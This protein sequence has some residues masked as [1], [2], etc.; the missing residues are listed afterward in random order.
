M[1]HALI[2]NGI[3]AQTDPVAGHRAGGAVA[4][5]PLL[6]GARPGC[7]RTADAR[8]LRDSACARG[9]RWGVIWHDFCERPMKK[10]E[11]RHPRHAPRK[12]ARLCPISSLDVYH[13]NAPRR[14]AFA[15]W[16]SVF[17]WERGEMMRFVLI[18][19]VGKTSK[20]RRETSRHTAPAEPAMGSRR[21]PSTVPAADARRL[22]DVGCAFVYRSGVIRRDFCESVMSKIENRN[23]WCASS[24]CRVPGPRWIGTSLAGTRAA[25]SVSRVGSAH[26]R[27]LYRRCRAARS[28]KK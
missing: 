23:V 25:A 21:R 26:I 15:S 9:Y 2:T 12:N 11:N 28:S 10:L 4:N 8:R 27:S 24:P 14:V 5:A 20:T 22:R 1:P 3:T 18:T 13:G 6:C 19:K 7:G 17:S 16:R